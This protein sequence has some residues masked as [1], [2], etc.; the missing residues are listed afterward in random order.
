MIENDPDSPGPSALVDVL[1]TYFALGDELA[2]LAGH[3]ALP[4]RPNKFSILLA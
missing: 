1:E 3:V 2:V 4:N